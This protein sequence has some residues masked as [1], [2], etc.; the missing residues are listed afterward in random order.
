M[1]SR[2]KCDVSVLREL[3]ELNWS[4]PVSVVLRHIFLKIGNGFV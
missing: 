2:I 3:L 1:A 4:L